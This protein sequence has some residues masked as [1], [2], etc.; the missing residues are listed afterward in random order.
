MIESKNKQTGNPLSIIPKYT[1]N[2]LLDWQMTENLSANV[3]WTMYGKQK[4]MTQATNWLSAEQ[5][6][7]RREVASYSVTGVGASY[8]ITKNLSINAGISNLF[9]K[10]IYRMADGASSYNEPGRAYY[11]GMKATF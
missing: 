11:A 3:N 8:T 2:T 4:P 9:D 1:V 7:S 5:G 6:L 10:R